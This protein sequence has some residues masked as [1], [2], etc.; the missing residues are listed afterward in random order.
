V[1]IGQDINS[2][3]SDLNG[4]FPKLYVGD[5]IIAEQTLTN[6]IPPHYTDFTAAGPWTVVSG[7]AITNTVR[8]ELSTE[9]VNRTT[10]DATLSVSISSEVSTRTADDATLSTNLSAEV[11]NRTTGDATLSTNLSTEV[12]TRTADDA[13]LSTNLSAEVV[14]RTTGDATLSTNLS[15]EVST[16]TADDATLSTNLSAEVSTRTAADAALSTS[17]TAIEKLKVINVAMDDT[18]PTATFFST[19]LGKQANNI[20]DSVKLVYFNVNDTRSG[21]RNNNLLLHQSTYG[22]YY[23]DSTT[24]N[25]VAFVKTSLA[26]AT[27]TWATV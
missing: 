7:S 19:E 16:R 23:F 24:I 12:S 8:S 22:D 9:V 13:T 18:S 10:G 26:G 17:V 25:Q 14:N 6:Q 20:T 1:I 11:V 27:A 4:V 21:T 15:T 2:S 5:V 3:V